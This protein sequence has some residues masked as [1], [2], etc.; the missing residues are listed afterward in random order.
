MARFELISFVLCPYVQKSIMALEERGLEYDITYIDLGN[1]PAWFADISPMGKVPLLKVEGAVIFESTVINEY[2]EETTDQPLHPADAIERA[3]NRSWAEYISQM[4]MDVHRIMVG[5]DS[6]EAGAHAQIVRSKLARL[7]TMLGDGPYFN[8][9]A[10][11]L[12]D[13]GAAP[14]LQ[15]IV[16]INAIAPM[17]NLFKK[18]PKVAAWAAALMERPSLKRSTVP[19]IHEQ[20]IS[21]LNGKGTP[22][23]DVPPSWVGRLAT[24]N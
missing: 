1:R 23:R 9:E 20:F 21:Y 13:C 11:S 19:D 16:W 2:I 18:T 7:E 10:F 8:G 17:L 5:T 24:K 3:H 22:T 4:N 6:A 14:P 15:R 12:V